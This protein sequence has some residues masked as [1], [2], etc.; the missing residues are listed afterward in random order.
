MYGYIAYT[1]KISQLSV[2]HTWQ[3]VLKYDRQFRVQQALTNCGWGED[4]PHLSSTWLVKKPPKV[5]VSNQAGNGN[6]RFTNNNDSYKGARNRMDGRQQSSHKQGNKA[7]D[8]APPEN[9]SL[10]NTRKCFYNPCR[11]MHKCVICNGDH[12]A[13]DN[14]CPTAVRQAFMAKNQ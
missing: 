12:A 9:C 3:S 13:V 7:E 8:D 5:N 10:F 6:A 14:A 2:E 4:F 11:F 1:L